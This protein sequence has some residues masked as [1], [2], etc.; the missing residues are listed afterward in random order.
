M[1]NKLKLANYSYS[2]KFLKLVIFKISVTF[3]TKQKCG[4]ISGSLRLSIYMRPESVK[5]IFE[6]FSC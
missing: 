6:V 5:F 3:L 2:K 4:D 1:E